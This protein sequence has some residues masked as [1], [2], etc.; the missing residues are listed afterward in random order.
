MLNFRQIEA[1]RAVML[2]GSMTQAA[3]DLHTSQP[4][5]SRVIAQLERRIGVKLFDRHAGKLMPTLEGQAFFR[6]VEHMFA[7]LLNLEDAANIIRQ[8]GVG[9]LRIV[10]VPSMAIHVVPEAMRTF[11]QD[12]PGV[13]LALHVA[14]S[15]TVCQWLAAGYADVGVVSEIFNATGIVAHTIQINAGVCVVSATHRLASL[16][17]AVTPQDLIGEK[18]LS[19]K[20][21]DTMRKKIDQAC[22][23]QGEEKRVLV[24]E[25][26]FAAAVFHM[27][28]RG[29]GVS[30][31]N[32]LMAA[33]YQDSVVM[34][35]FTPRIEFSTYVVLPRNRPV[36][37][38][39]QRF[40]Q[41][42]QKAADLA[43]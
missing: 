31:A 19:L 43:L 42:L 17:R 24:C 9:R 25:S 3:R 29:M 2:A 21:S 13:V 23:I 11:A 32:P 6:D 12:F 18:F 37:M 14:D 26:H 15:L 20:S 33:N 5:V 1:F 36:N 7:G 35:P 34:L 41:S 38:L 22:L 4:N 30:I 27:V 16:T 39:T 28:S 40:M 8:R 10:S